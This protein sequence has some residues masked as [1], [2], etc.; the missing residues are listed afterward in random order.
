MP[1]LGMQPIR[2]RQ[3][4]DATI[5][6][7]HEDGFAHTTISGISRR[8]GL[9]SGIVAHY[10]DDKA[11]LLEATMRKLAE[12]LRRQLVERLA[13][14]ESPEARL[15]AIIDANLADAQFTPEIMSA[16][17]SFWGQVRH[18][19]PLARIQRV[20]RQRMMSDLLHAAKLLLPPES[21]RRLAAGMAA[22]ID[23]LWMQRALAGERAKP[24]DARAVAHGYLAIQ[25][26]ALAPP[27]AN[28]AE[29]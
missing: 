4:I 11:G 29:T 27:A 12:D 1:K 26:A 13:R 5:A 24:A 16:W 28:G 18:S 25:L 8:A 23:G 6:S 3:L 10:F 7:I 15:A 9:S 17:L 14:A 20:Y 22:M 2:R 21:A 19:P